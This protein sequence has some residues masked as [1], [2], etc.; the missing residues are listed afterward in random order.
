MR[1]WLIVIGLIAGMGA[2]KAQQTP[3]YTQYV[4]N[5][6]FLNPANYGVYE[7]LDI[8]IGHRMQWVGFENA[9]ETSYLSLNKLFIQ[10]P[11]TSHKFGSIRISRPEHY[12]GLYSRRQNLHHA[13]G[14]YLIHEKNGPTT[15]SLLSLAYT[16]HV[17]FSSRMNLSIGLALGALKYQVDPQRITLGNDI[18]QTVNQFLGVNP[19]VT[20]L[21]S[22]FGVRL[23]TREF[24]IGY[25]MIQSAPSAISFSEVITEAKLEPHHIVHAGYAYRMS[26][27]FSAEPMLVIRHVSPY[28]LFSTWDVGLKGT[29]SSKYYGAL[30]YSHPGQVMASL[31]GTLKKKIRFGY[32]FTLGL[33]SL[34]GHHG[35][36]HGLMLG[37]RI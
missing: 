5:N 30:F 33:N 20:K 12:E 14:G 3:F 32:T 10:Q 23:Y 25:A 35:G 17:H 6:I 13:A 8:A 16:I 26:K 37:F 9:P 7:K 27:S 18:D 31:G 21:N 24:H 34:Q 1:N 22:D 15:S 29:I 19:S 36:S 2:L 11:R 28:K 4:H